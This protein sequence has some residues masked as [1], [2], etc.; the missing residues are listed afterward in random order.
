MNSPMTEPINRRSPN[1]RSSSRKRKLFS[2]SI[3]GWTVSVLV[4]T[5]LAAGFLLITFSAP[6]EDSNLPGA[7]AS[8]QQTPP[9][10]ETDPVITDLQIEPLVTEPLIVEPPELPVVQSHNPLNIIKSDAIAVY[11]P[12]ESGVITGQAQ[13]A[14]SLYRSDFF[15]VAGS[16][17]GADAAIVIRASNTHTFFESRILEI[18]C[19][20]RG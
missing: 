12:S 15:G 4:H 13:S 6:R 9:T 3:L 2:P 8:I 20:P 16:A 11:N 14:A 1:Q 10:L 18:I 19:K 7:I 17:R 5:G